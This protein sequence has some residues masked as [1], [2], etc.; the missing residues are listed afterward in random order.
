MIGDE[1]N[2]RDDKLYAIFL[3]FLESDFN[4][5]SQKIN[6]FFAFAIYFD[7]DDTKKLVKEIKLKIGDVEF[8]RKLLYRQAWGSDAGHLIEY[9]DEK[10]N[11][12]FDVAF[13]KQLLKLNTTITEYIFLKSKDLYPHEAFDVSKINFG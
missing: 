7:D 1:N 4:N 11:P 12:S 9:V 3:R 6:F 10:D 5:L 13:E 8:H 2:K